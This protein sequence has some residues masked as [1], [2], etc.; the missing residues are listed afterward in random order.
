MLFGVI[1]YIVGCLFSFCVVL[2]CCFVGVC[3]CFV[4]LVAGLLFGVDLL[5]VG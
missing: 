1:R 2:F 3:D 5:L 4:V